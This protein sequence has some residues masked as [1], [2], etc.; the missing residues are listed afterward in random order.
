MNR[1]DLF[2]KSNRWATKL[3]TGIRAV[4]DGFWLGMLDHAALQGLTARQYDGDDSYADDVHNLSGLHH[5]EIGALDRYFSG[6]RTLLVGAAGA[7]REVIGLAGRGFR[8]DGFD[9]SPKFF[10]RGRSLCQARGVAANFLFAAPGEVPEEA[11]VY[12]GLIMGWGGYIHIAGRERRIRFLREFRKHVK[13]GGPLLIS[14]LSRSG[15]SGRVKI[16]FA[17]AR[18]VRAL[19]LSREPLEMGD[20][21]AGNWFQHEFTEAEIRHELEQAGFRVEYYSGRFGG[22]AVGI[23]EE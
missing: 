19:R 10:E 16:P 7:G 8:A 6:C 12:D 1:P 17:V 3:I 14:F 13:A 4:H 23:A 2:L 22:H 9:C 18:L 21:L 15:G 5:W 20:T 11:G